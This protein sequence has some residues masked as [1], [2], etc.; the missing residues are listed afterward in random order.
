MILQ[1]RKTADRHLQKQARKEGSSKVS[2]LKLKK[3]IK[4]VLCKKLTDNKNISQFQNIFPPDLTNFSK[5]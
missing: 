2:F 5:A 4:I 3:K 1:R